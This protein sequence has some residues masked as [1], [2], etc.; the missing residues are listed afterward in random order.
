MRIF[1]RKKKPDFDATKVN[2]I[3]DTPSVLSSP[4]IH[5]IICSICKTTYVGEMRHVTFEQNP[6]LLIPSKT[7]KMYCP[8]CQTANNVNFEIKEDETNDHA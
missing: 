7:A 4:I 5:P 8:V 3:L 2:E 6:L 1:K